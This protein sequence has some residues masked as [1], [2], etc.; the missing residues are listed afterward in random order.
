MFPQNNNFGFYPNQNFN[1]FKGIKKGIN[2]SNL[3]SNTQKTLGI[4]NQAI[5]VVYQI[6]PIVKNAKTLFKVAHEIKKPDIKNSGIKKTNQK[7]NLKTEI[8]NNTP[9]FFQ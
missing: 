9:T 6:K 7:S 2:W 1:Q 3:L 5:P 4:I 8:N